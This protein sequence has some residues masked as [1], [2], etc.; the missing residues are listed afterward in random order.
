MEAI[1]IPVKHLDTAKLRLDGALGAAGRRQLARALLSDVL[2]AASL[3]PLRLLV[4]A[5]AEV[6]STGRAA[7]WRAVEDPGTGL[8]GALAAGTQVAMDLGATALV[9]LPFDVP[10]VTAADL[11]ALF[12]ATAA[13]VVAPSADGG[14]GALMRRPPDV[15]RTQFGAFSAA[16]H[17]AGARAAGVAVTTMHREGLGL[18]IDDLDDLRLLAASASDGA[19]ARAAR[20]LLASQGLRG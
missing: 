4:T 14:T 2:A 13:V 12:A 6:A 5:D 18:D 7:G 11:E 19:S 15:V 3:W 9:V 10:L 16:A 17:E 8:N 1:L 20:E